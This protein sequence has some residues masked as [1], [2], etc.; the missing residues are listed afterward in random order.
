[1]DSDSRNMAA[2]AKNCRERLTYVI[3]P[4]LSEPKAEL[5]I[6]FL[7]PLGFCTHLGC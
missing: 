4:L 5:S 7:G 2:T 6:R 3:R 1:M